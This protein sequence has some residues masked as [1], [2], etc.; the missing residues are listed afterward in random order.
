MSGPV[1]HPKTPMKSIG[2]RDIVKLEYDK[3]GHLRKEG[4]LERSFIGNF[5]QWRQYFVVVRDGCCYVFDNDQSTQ[6]K[7]AFSLE[8]YCRLECFAKTPNY[9]YCFKLIPKASCDN[10]K[11]HC[12]A[13]SD[14]IGRKDWLIAIYKALHVANNI[15]EPIEVDK[16]AWNED[17]FQNVHGNGSDNKGDRHQPRRKYSKM[18]TN[19]TGSC[20]PKISNAFY[21]EIP[22]DPDSDIS[23]QA[24]DDKT[25]PRWKECSINKRLPPLPPTANDKS[26]TITA[27]ECP[28]Y[29][30]LDLKKKIYTWS[31][32]WNFPYSDLKTRCEQFPICIGRIIS[33][34]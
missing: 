18:P 22:H 13:T 8:N 3:C 11:E 21:D 26:G 7:V 16:E 32:R 20:C 12:F 24:Y 2:A 23:L 17:I 30:N 33:T 5:V 27:Q 14:D 34:E 25:T 29:M 6:P 9:D 1:S 15:P 31:V 4:L 28:T 19:P 10:L